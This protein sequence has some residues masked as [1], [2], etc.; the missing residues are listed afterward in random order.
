MGDRERATKERCWSGR[1][2]TPG[3][4]VEAEMFH[5]GSNPTLSGENVER[6]KIGKI[7]KERREFIGLSL[8]EIERRTYISKR[9]LEALENDDISQ[10]PKVSYATSIIRAYGRFLGLEDYEIAGLVREFNPKIAPKF[11]FFGRNSIIYII[12]FLLVIIA[13][14]ILKS[15]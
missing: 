11:I 14:L 3:K 6:G 1:T 12:L 2:G 13:F 15:L 4:R 7:L 9:Y 5:V 10:F 8:D